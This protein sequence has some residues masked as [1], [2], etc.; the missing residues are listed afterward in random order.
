V[1]R[2]V[3]GL[4]G[5]DPGIGLPW[6]DVGGEAAVDPSAAKIETVVW[7]GGTRWGRITNG[8]AS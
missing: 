3:E 5:D 4:A 1:T 7:L 6:D 2:G 8:M